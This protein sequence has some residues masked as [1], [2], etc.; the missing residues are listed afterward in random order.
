MSK[1]TLKSLAKRV[2][3]LEQLL[4]NQQPVKDWRLAAGMFVP[5]KFSKQV[6]AEGRKI[7]EADRRAARKAMGQ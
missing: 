7:R 1:V 4:Q 2:S 5:S 6:D 3:A